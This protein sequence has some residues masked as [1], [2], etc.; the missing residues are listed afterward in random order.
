M[1]LESDEES[2]LGVE[3]FTKAIKINAT[4]KLHNKGCC[5]AV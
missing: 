5:D 4:L 1:G 2:L 3:F